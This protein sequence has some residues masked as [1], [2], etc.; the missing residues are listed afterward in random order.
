M[1]RV[2]LCWDIRSTVKPM[3][4][5][6]LFGSKPYLH[7]FSRNIILA[8]SRQVQRRDI[9]KQKQQRRESFFLAAYINKH[10]DALLE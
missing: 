7:T 3:K 10:R 9:R 2:P 6:A 8:F 5:A 1:Q 4:D